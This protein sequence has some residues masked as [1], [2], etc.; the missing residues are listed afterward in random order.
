MVVAQLA[1]A[2][3]RPDAGS[4]SAADHAVDPFNNI[5]LYPVLRRL[6]YPYAVATPGWA[7]CAVR[8]VFEA[9]AAWSGPRWFR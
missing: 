9:I 7:V 1:G 8:P 5:V 2:G 6:G 3:G 4:E